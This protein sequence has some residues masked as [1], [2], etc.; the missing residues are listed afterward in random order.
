[1]LQSSQQ[2]AVSYP[3]FPGNVEA[4]PT[5]VT[6]TDIDDSNTTSEIIAKFGNA[7]A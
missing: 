4:L 1:M 3:T 7:K 6:T 2:R 5:I